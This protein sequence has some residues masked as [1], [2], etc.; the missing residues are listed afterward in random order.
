MKEP[1]RTELQP[2]ELVFAVTVLHN[3]RSFDKDRFNYPFNYER[4]SI[5][6]KSL[7][8][9]EPK[10]SLVFDPRGRGDATRRVKR[11]DDRWFVGSFVRSFVRAVIAGSYQFRVPGAMFQL[12]NLHLLRF[13]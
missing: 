4:R 3:V 9:L 11:N 2:N 8:K 6:V 1:A 13:D 5:I 7:G 10:I 12:N